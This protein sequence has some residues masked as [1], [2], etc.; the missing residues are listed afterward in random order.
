MYDSGI[1]PPRAAW[2]ALLA[3]SFLLSAL[4]TYSSHAQ[5]DINYVT[6]SGTKPEVQAMRTV[7]SQF[8][9]LDGSWKIYVDTGNDDY[10][11]IAGIVKSG[12]KTATGH[13]LTITSLSSRSD[14]Y[15]QIVIGDVSSDSIA[16]IAARY[17]RNTIGLG[18]EG[19]NLILVTAHPNLAAFDATAENRAKFDRIGEKVEEMISDEE[20]EE[21]VEKVY[22]NIRDIISDRWVREIKFIEEE[23]GD[24]DGE[25]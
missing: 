19:Y 10:N 25:E 18:D 11:T 5:Y 9:L 16:T 2:G 17:Q 20:S 21:I 6:S 14:A 12:I 22:P 3:A 1:T 13:D 7:D 4:L 24:G 8:G 23:E 15:D